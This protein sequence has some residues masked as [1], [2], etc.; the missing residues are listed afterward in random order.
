MNDNENMEAKLETLLRNAGRNIDLQSSVPSFWR[1]WLRARALV[2]FGGND[3]QAMFMPAGAAAVV[4]AAL[5]IGQ[6]LPNVNTAPQ[7]DSRYVN[8]I[9][10]TAFEDVWESPSDS[11]L[12]MDTIDPI[13]K[14]RK[15]NNQMDARGN[16][17][18][19]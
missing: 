8:T 5:L 2:W 12:T 19:R 3:L 13:N 15:N 10:M 9:D 1:V 7:G 17:Q 6:L 18:V 11:L 4:M 14:R 16:G